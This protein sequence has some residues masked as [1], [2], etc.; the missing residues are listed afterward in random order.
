MWYHRLGTYVM[1]WSTQFFHLYLSLDSAENACTSAKLISSIW[2]LVHLCCFKCVFLPQSQFQFCDEL[3]L[4][5]VCFKPVN[6]PCLPVCITAICAH[7]VRGKKSFYFFP[8]NKAHRYH[9]TKYSSL[10]TLETRNYNRKNFHRPPAF[11]AWSDMGMTSV[12]TT[13]RTKHNA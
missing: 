9:F 11:V 6:T 13:N 3:L 4:L 12:T 2:L 5:L 7:C 1:Q 8:P 10:N